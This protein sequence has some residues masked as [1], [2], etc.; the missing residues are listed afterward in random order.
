MSSVYVAV[1]N[2]FNEYVINNSFANENVID[3]C[4]FLLVLY[5]SDKSSKYLANHD[6]NAK[7]N[8]DAKLAV[9]YKFDA[10]CSSSDDV[11]KALVSFESKHP[12]DAVVVWAGACWAMLEQGNLHPLYLNNGKV[13]CMED[14]CSLN[15][16]N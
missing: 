4:K 1:R 13:C 5:N 15:S 12:G 8:P 3:V 10:L 6:I 14:T 2:G 11:Y 16:V 7:R 9:P